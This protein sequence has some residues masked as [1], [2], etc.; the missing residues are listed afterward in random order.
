MKVLLLKPEHKEA[1]KKENKNKNRDMGILP[2]E[3]C[4]KSYDSFLQRDEIT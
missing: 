2:G 3:L 4:L 1:E